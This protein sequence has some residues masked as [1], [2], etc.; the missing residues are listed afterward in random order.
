M[1]ALRHVGAVLVAV[2]SLSWQPSLGAPSTRPSVEP[3][4]ATGA[5]PDEVP[6]E[7]SAPVTPAHHAPKRSFAKR[8]M[9]VR[10]GVRRPVKP[11]ARRIVRPRRP[12]SA[13][14]SRPHLVRRPHAIPV[15]QHC[16]VYHR[17]RLTRAD[18]PLGPQIEAF[19][20]PAELASQTPEVAFDETVRPGF[21]DEEG[22]QPGGGGAFSNRA[23]T[24]DGGGPSGGGGTGPVSGAPEPAAWS[25]LIVGIA[26]IGQS[27]R[28]KIE[29]LS[30]K[31][32]SLDV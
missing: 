19:T 6:C 32:R 20:A 28:R 24:G 9:R 18:L 10:R 16:Y 7:A 3:G 5:V 29:P 14:R 23:G 31:A 17:S 13:R 26:L 2:A 11:A 30:A 25:L 27:L 22:S 1:R 4:S 21:L 12:H 15:V 8:R